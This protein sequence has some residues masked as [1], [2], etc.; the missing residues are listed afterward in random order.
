MSTREVS[1]TTKRNK[2]TFEH[3]INSSDV[4]LPRKKIWKPLKPEHTRYFFQLALAR[5][6]PKIY[7][8]RQNITHPGDNILKFKKIITGCGIL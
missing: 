6:K 5:A 7:R 3:E 4:P 1:T 2:K 8:I